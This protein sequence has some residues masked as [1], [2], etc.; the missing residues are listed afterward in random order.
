MQMFFFGHFV[1]MRESEKLTRTP[2]NALDETLEDRTMT[3]LF[4]SDEDDDGLDYI[5]MTD[6]HVCQG[7]KAKVIDVHISPDR[8]QA[9]ID[10]EYAVFV[11]HGSDEVEQ[12]ER[13]LE[14]KRAE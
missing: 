3:H 1:R 14:A 12:F 10:T 11:V 8:E 13:R 6:P 9:F 5:F 4:E 7:V 2:Q